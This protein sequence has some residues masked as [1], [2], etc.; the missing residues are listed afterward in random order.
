MENR[1]NLTYH[2]AGRWFIASPRMHSVRSEGEA[3]E[4]VNSPWPLKH[5]PKGGGEECGAIARAKR[6]GDLM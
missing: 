1:G 4:T 5:G 3:R 2:R 6:D